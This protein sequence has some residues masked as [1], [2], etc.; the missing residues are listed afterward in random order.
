MRIAKADRM[1]LVSV[2]EP[3]VNRT[4]STIDL[5]VQAINRAKRELEVFHVEIALLQLEVPAGARTNLGRE[6]SS[7]FPVVFLYGRG[8]ASWPSAPHTPPYL[9]T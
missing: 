9:P 5:V 6:F 1:P 8:C 3:H 7:N 2:S 4:C